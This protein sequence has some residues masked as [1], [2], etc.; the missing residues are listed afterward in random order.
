MGFHQSRLSQ[1]Q[2]SQERKQLLKQIPPLLLSRNPVPAALTLGQ[3]CI[4]SLERHPS[5]R[6]H[7]PHPVKA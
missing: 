4:P 6:A 1:T 3:L 5:S 7:C 2:W